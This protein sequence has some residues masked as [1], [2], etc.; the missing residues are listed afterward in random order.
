MASSS[1]LTVLFYST[2]AG[3]E[4]EFANH[5]IGLVN[6][7]P[8]HSLRSFKVKFDMFENILENQFKKSMRYSKI[9]NMRP[10]K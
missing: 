10:K 3:I 5:F 9:R 7:T 6:T 2:A 1:T 8:V 4:K